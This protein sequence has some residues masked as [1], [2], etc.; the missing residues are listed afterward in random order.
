MP[1]KE[2]PKFVNL[3]TKLAI[4]H[5]FHTKMA[6]IPGGIRAYING[7]WLVVYVIK[8]EVRGNHGSQTPENELMH[9]AEQQSRILR[10]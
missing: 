6:L 1:Q 7:V 2:W 9:S 4:Y 3:Y 10:P 8:E 5:A